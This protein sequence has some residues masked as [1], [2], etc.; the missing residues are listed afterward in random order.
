MTI[1]AYTAKRAKRKEQKL[2]DKIEEEML[3]EYFF[4]R[5]L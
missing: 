1:G 3:D 5:K 4:G 2:R